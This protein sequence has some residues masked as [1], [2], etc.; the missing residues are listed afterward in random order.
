MA[1][2]RGRG[3]SST[4]AS[5]PPGRPLVIL[6]VLIV[7]V[8]SLKIG[9]SGIDSLARSGAPFDTLA[10]LTKGG[11]GNGVLTP[12]V[13]LVPADEAQA[14]ADAAREVDG[15][16]VSV[17]GSDEADVAVLDVLPEDETVDSSGNEVV[18]AV[19]NAVQGAVE[20]D[21]GVTGAGATVEDY[22]SAV[23]DRFPYVLA[24]IAV[25]TFILLVRTFRSILL[26]IKAV[27]LNLVS[28]AA[29]FGSV[30]FFWQMGHGS[31]LDLQ[32]L[33]D[34]RDHLLA[35]RADLRVP[36]RVVD[37]LRGLHPGPDAR[38]VRRDRRHR[39]G[40]DHRAR[41]DRPA[42]DV[43]GADPV[44]RLRRAGLRTRAPTSRCWAPRSGSA[45]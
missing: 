45:S 22:F 14:A 20:G 8:F 1:G 17:V 23:Y 10:T 33:R 16:Q 7:P 39:R 2:P 40:G 18:D 4:T 21:V 12:I 29:V 5:S 30:V 27:I 37:G 32:R 19:R 42:G 31:D 9:N 36:V 38:G 13:V 34:R 15:V 11:I 3:A 25:I 41:P 24:L 6:A 44:L 26:P 28:L 43:R 35:A